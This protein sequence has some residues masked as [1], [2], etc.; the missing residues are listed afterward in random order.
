MAHDATRKIV[1]TTPQLSE[2]LLLEFSNFLSVVGEKIIISKS[3]YNLYMISV[4]D[5]GCFC[6]LTI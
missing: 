4:F 1:T 3:R 5:L 6:S 2:A